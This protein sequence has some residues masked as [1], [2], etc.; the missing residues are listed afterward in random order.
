MLGAPGIVPFAIV[1]G[2]NRNLSCC[3]KIKLGPVPTK[4]AV[5]PIEEEYAIPNNTAR[6]YFFN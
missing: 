4:V 5:P 3:A 1:R 6:V 2:G